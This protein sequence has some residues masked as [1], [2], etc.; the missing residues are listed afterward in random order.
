M[1]SPNQALEGSS[2]IARLSS[3]L[4]AEYDTTPFRKSSTFSAV[5]FQVVQVTLLGFGHRSPQLVALGS[6]DPV[7]E[8][9]GL[10]ALKVSGRNP[11]RPICVLSGGCVN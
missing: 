7:R 1:V 4:P 9:A 8:G 2:E 11:E 5:A 6:I 3:T 10:F